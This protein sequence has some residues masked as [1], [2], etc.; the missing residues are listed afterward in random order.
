MLR[1]RIGDGGDAERQRLAK[2]VVDDRRTAAIGDPRHLDSQ[3]L[4]ELRAGEVRNGAVARHAE[5]GLIRMGLEPGDKL[6]EIELLEI[7]AQRR[8]AHDSEFEAGEQR[9]WNEVLCGVEARMGLNH[10]QQ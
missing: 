8:S 1:N 9:N 5:C 6:L 2:Q 10:R 7:V 3:Y 4:L